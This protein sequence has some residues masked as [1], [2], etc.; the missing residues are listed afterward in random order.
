MQYT[1][2]LGKKDLKNILRTQKVQKGTTDIAV[3]LV[4]DRCYDST[5]QQTCIAIKIRMK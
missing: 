3:L 5:L 1:I 4:I 2:K